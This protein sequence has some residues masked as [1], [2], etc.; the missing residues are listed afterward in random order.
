MYSGKTWIELSWSAAQVDLAGADVGLGRRVDALG[1][2][3]AGVDLGEEGGLGEVRR[4]RRRWRRR[5]SSGAALRR[6]GGERVAAASRRPA[7]RGRRRRT[8][9]ARAVLRFIG[10]SLSWW[11]GAGGQAASRGGVGRPVRQVRGGQPC[12]SRA[13]HPPCGTAFVI[14]FV[15]RP[16]ARPAQARARRRGAGGAASSTS[17][18]SGEQ[19]DESAP[20]AGSA[21]S[22]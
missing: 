14:A 15:T 4:R 9:A 20:P 18:A 3:R 5:A 21:R 10:R 11:P 8:T 17:S 12:R 19:G 2:Q 16:T 13:I 1:A 6:V 7:A 22:R